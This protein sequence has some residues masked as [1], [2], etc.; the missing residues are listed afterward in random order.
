MPAPG[1]SVF[2]I[3]KDAAIEAALRFFADAV[4]HG[5][6]P[7]NDAERTRPLLNRVTA[8]AGWEAQ[9]TD[10]YRDVSQQLRADAIALAKAMLDARMAHDL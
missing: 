4:R 10:A 7:K 5:W 1:C 9:L 3:A 2:R 6:D 8:L